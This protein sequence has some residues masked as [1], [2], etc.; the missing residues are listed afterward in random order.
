MS[1]N[2]QQKNIFKKN[3]KKIGDGFERNENLEDEMVK[4]K[5]IRAP[6]NSYDFD[7]LF[8]AL[9][10]LVS[11]YV[12]GGYVI[13]ARYGVNKTTIRKILKKHLST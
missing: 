11:M 2:F 8:K 7:K 4:Y 1:A 13:I 12:S 9:K 10:G 5:I 3:C 6:S